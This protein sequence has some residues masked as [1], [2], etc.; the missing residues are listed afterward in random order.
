[1]LRFV[2]WLWLSQSTS[3]IYPLSLLLSDQEVKARVSKKE[4]QQLKPQ[5]RGCRRIQIKSNHPHVYEGRL[6]SR[7]IFARV[8]LRRS[9]QGIASLPRA[10][11]RSEWLRRRKGGEVN[12]LRLAWLM[13]LYMPLSFGETVFGLAGVFKVWLLLLSRD[14]WLDTCQWRTI[15]VKMNEIWHCMVPFSTQVTS[16]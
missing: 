3:S 13:C 6:F 14:T 2:S 7:L 9:K 1:M 15:R 5:I 11:M 10:C 4:N 12:M 16:C 8:W